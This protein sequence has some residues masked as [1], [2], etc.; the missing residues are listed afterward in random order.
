MG[1]NNL[2]KVVNN[3]LG[4]VVHT[5]VPLSHETEAVATGI[6]GGK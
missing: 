2:P 6:S 5:H 3:N 1:V 4:Q